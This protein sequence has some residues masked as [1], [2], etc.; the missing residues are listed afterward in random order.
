MRTA[1]FYIQFLMGVAIEIDFFKVMQQ[2][3]IIVFIPMLAG[4]LTRKHFVK[5][6][7]LKDFKQNIDPKFPPLSTL[8]VVGIVFIAMALKAKLIAASPGMLFYILVP[9]IIIYAFNFFLSSLVGKLLLPRGD[10][11]ALAIAINA[12]G[13]EGE[14]AALVVAVAYIIQVESAVWYVKLTN[15]IFIKS[16]I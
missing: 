15:K 2:I 10:A 9:L 5:K 7:G 1:P 6:Y 13:K 3:I 12:F 8:G 4:F 14:S 16:L 11:I